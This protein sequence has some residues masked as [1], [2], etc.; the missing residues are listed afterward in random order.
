M[1]MIKER[2]KVD[3]TSANRTVGPN[4]ECVRWIQKPLVT[5]GSACLPPTRRIFFEGVFAD[6]KKTSGSTSIDASRLI[7]QSAVFFKNRLDAKKQAGPTSLFFCN[8]AVK[9]SEFIERTLS[10]SDCSL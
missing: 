2:L 10:T 9:T 7:F 1:A 6:E 8:Q 5:P 4:L 3:W